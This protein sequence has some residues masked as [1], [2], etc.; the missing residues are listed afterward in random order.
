MH[1]YACIEFFIHKIMLKIKCL[2]KLYTRTYSVIAK[3]R[4][5]DTQR[6]HFDPFLCLLVL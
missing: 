4:T 5:T 6:T 3:T 1:T 2:V